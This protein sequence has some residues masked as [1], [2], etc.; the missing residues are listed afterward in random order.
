VVERVRKYEGGR[1]NSSA[2]DVDDVDVVDVGCFER[3]DDELEFDDFD[4]VF[5]I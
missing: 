4:D 2:N 3:F 1:K 5:C